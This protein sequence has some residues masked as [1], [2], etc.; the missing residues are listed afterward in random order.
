MNEGDFGKLVKERR[1]E[2]DL[3]QEALEELSGVSQ[4]TISRI[5]ND[6][7]YNPSV[8]SKN[9]L[10]KALKLP[11]VSGASFLDNLIIQHLHGLSDGDKKTLLRFILRLK[12][13]AEPE[14]SKILKSIPKK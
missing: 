13:V 7:D 14:S 4:S 10:L 8:K 6:P 5:E 3:S 9:E 11:E 1:E 12:N 2:L